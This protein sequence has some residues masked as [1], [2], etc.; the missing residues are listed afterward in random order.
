MSLGGGRR[1]RRGPRRRCGPRARGQVLADDRAAICGRMTTAPACVAL[2][3]LAG[4]GRHVAADTLLG[5]RN[6]LPLSGPQERLSAGS[7]ASLYDGPGTLNPLRPDRLGEA[8]VARA[9][10][11]TADGPCSGRSFPWLR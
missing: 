2:A 7:A 6:R 11:A 10:R 4:A 1:Y 9:L 3:T 8:L 5:C